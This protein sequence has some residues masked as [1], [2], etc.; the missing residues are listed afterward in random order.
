MP[1]L[2]SSGE[3]LS[4]S[5]QIGNVI[6]IVVFWNVSPFSLIGGCQCFGEINCLYHQVDVGD[7]TSY[8]ERALLL[9]LIARPHNSCTTDTGKQGTFFKVKVLKTIFCAPSLCH[10]VRYVS[11]L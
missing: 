5:H 10:R 7:M 4:C 11:V 9:F 2:F 8:Q 6:E 1:Q 3:K